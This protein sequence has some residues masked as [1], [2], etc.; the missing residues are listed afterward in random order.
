MASSSRLLGACCECLSRFALCFAHYFFKMC[1]LMK[2]WPLWH[3]LA[4]V[5]KHVFTGRKQTIHNVTAGMSWM[6]RKKPTRNDSALSWWNLFA[7][8][9]SVYF[10]DSHKSSGRC[11]PNRWSLLFPCSLSEGSKMKSSKETACK[12]NQHT[13]LRKWVIIIPS[14]HFCTLI[15][16]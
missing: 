6:R 11:L 12:D 16:I 10:W 13:V 14:W 5:S 4:L 9:H 1:S 7:T 8:W 15:T 2:C 3:G